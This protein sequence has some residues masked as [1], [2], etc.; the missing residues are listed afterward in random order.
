MEYKA[1]FDKINALEAKYLDILE[2]ACNIESPT[3]DKEAV[4]RVAA[5][6]TDAFSDLPVAVKKYPIEII[7]FSFFA[8]GYNLKS[9]IAKYILFKK[10]IFYISQY[11]KFKTLT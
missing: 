3:A 6:L 8:Y 9:V 4:D 10:L 11:H 7:N 2:A 1:L 5:F